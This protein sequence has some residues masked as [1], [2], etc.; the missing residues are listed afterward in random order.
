MTETAFLELKQKAAQLS[1]R[2]RRALIVFL[3][4]GRQGGAAWKKEAARRL[5][6]M[7]RGE[8]TSV[9]ALR[10]SIESC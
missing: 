10:K 8:K 3:Q 5:D 1:D 2:E 9:A 7:G 6:A 4:R